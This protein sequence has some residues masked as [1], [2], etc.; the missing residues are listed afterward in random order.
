M[1]VAVVNI[2]DISHPRCLVMDVQEQAEIDKL[3]LE[4]LNGT[5]SEESWS[6][7]TRF[8]PFRWL[9]VVQALREVRSFFSRTS[10]HSQASPR[11]TL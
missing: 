10:R 6:Q 3:T 8:L 9:S 4:T 2:N 11:T 7:A 5:Q 1:E